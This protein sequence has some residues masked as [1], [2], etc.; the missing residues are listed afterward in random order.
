VRVRP[1]DWRLGFVRLRL[2]GR[3]LERVPEP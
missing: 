2:A 1:V 3:L